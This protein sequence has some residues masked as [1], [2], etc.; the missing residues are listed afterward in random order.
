MPLMLV[1]LLLVAV[2][3]SNISINLAYDRI[4]LASKEDLAHMGDFTLDLIEGYHR[5][6]EVYRKER[7]LA[8]KRELQDMVNLAYSLVE[9][10]F[11]QRKKEKLPLAS[12]KREAKA[13][14]E[15]SSL[16][17]GAAIFVMDTSGELLVKPHTN[18]KSLSSGS[19]ESMDDLF[20]RISQSAMMSQPGEVLYLPGSSV[21]E[22]SDDGAEPH[23]AYR[24]FPEWGWIIIAA[25]SNGSQMNEGP[26]E[27]QA[28]VELKERIKE[29]HVGKTGFIYVADC[30]GQLVIHPEYETES[31]YT[32]MEKGALESF[33][34]SCR[35]GKGASWSRSVHYLGPDV[36]SRASIARLEYFPPWDWVVFVEAFEDEL[37]GS[38]SET[39]T[40][41]L[42]SVI[43]LSL[44]V[45]VFAG[46]V[47]FYAAKRFTFPIFMMTEEIARAREGRLL[48]KITVPHAE[49]LKK[50]AIAFN[51]M[52][53]MIRRD[54]ELEEKLAR[55]EK[56]AS[57]GVLSS[58][59]AHEINNPMGVIL[60][61]ACHLE[62]KLDKDDRNL[63]FVQEIKQESKR[64]VKIVQSLL[65]YA[66][67]PRISPETTNVNAL[68]HQIIDFASGHAELQNIVTDKRFVQDL[69]DINVD[70]DQ[71]RQV[72]M[73]LI[74]NGAAAMVDGGTLRITTSQVEQGVQIEVRDTGAG[75]PEGHLGEVFEP[76]FTTKNKGTG[77]G[78]AIS[79]QIVEAHMGEID[80][81]S[82][83]GKGTTVRIVLP[84]DQR[85]EGGRE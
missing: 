2:F 67:V 74:L 21:I 73:N 64:C 81:K 62:T 35:S 79:K 56:M 84:I 70:A 71:L 53:D 52:S 24:Y 63:H 14:L 13:G 8:Q 37:F 23:A 66:R 15:S 45:S 43:F 49:E 30:K 55:M 68:L 4:V 72:M 5:Q 36:E 69:P 9:T 76:F 60:G 7:S 80:I 48:K 19:G 57:I 54:K 78:L 47:A 65:D 38:A 33:A 22:K 59:V 29:K 41:I 31:V 39:R 50:L 75:I 51:N 42:V 34:A 58:G 61:Y 46:M 82:E 10:H 3:I 83:N 20:L 27:G 6:Y 26:T 17:E 16:G 12:V 11:H 1:P 44:F 25:A 40:N 28:F 32:R 85:L 77:L 18:T